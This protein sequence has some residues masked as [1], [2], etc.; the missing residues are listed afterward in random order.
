MNSMIT[1]RDMMVTKVWQLGPEQSAM[2]GIE[3]LLKHRITGA[4]VV[5]DG[6]FL[7]MFSE[8]CSLSL[9][10]AATTEL[11][12]ITGHVIEGPPALKFATRDVLVLSPDED[13]FVA[14]GHL[15]NHR[16]SGA[17]V[18]DTEGRF[19]GSFSEKTSMNV[20]IRGAYDQLPST[21]VKSFM[22][23]D[24]DR[25]IHEDMNLWAVAGMFA[26]TRYR[27]LP[28]VRDGR[29]LGQISRCDVLRAGYPLLCELYDK[30]RVKLGTSS[31]VADG[32]ARHA[33]MLDAP[34]SMSMDVNART[35]RPEADWMEIASIF[36]HTN[37][38]RLQ[39]LDPQ[40]KLLG[41]LSR[42]DLLC[43]VYHMLDPKKECSKPHPLYLSG[44]HE[45]A[46]ETFS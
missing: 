10:S 25:V 33:S 34:V 36:S 6:M 17:P 22:D 24:P 38:R 37:Y 19:L 20:V 15:L 44:L 18:V 2:E 7:G 13:V 45:D 4:P 29:V 23:T 32:E 11:S 31:E 28:V 12:E 14:I 41:Q 27:R 30:H 3:W 21:T 43:A 16:I 5:D 8:K 35:I 42:R 9:F 1:S 39:V 40:G 46:A 26:S